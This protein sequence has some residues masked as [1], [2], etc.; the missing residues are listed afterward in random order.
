MKA[1]LSLSVLIKTKKLNAQALRVLNYGLLGAVALLFLV[2]GYFFYEDLQ[3]ITTRNTLQNKASEAFG[4]TSY[5]EAAGYLRELGQVYDGPERDL[6]LAHALHLDQ[7]TAARDQYELSTRA[8]GYP[9]LAS[10]AFQQLG[11]LTAAEAMKNQQAS[12]E[13]IDA[14]LEYHKDAL[15]MNAE[16]EAARENY[17]TLYRLKERLM[18]QQQQNQENQDQNQENQQNQDQQQDQQNKDQQNQDQKE[19]N[20]NQDGQNSEQQKDEQDGQQK[21]QEQGQQDQ[22]GERKKAQEGQDGEQDDAQKQKQLAERLKDM[23]LSVE[24]AQMLLEAMKNQERKY[25]QQ[26][27]KKAKRKPPKTG[28]K[29]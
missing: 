5:Q 21:K 28:P 10:V 1:S 29:W 14:A 17:E 11:V 15:R 23:N 7:D 16:N 12:M 25:L 9:G 4:L 20:K 19:N 3:K 26:N 22:N 6:N 2:V 13:A 8:T 27:R 24:K 18:Q